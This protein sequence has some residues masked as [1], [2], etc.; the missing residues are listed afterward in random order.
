MRDVLHSSF[1][2]L[3]RIYCLLFLLIGFGVSP[4]LVSQEC[5]DPYSC[6]SDSTVAQP[7]SSSQSHP[8][9][10]KEAILKNLLQQPAIKISL[11]NIDIQWGITQRS[12]SPFDPVINSEILHTYSRDL[13]NLSPFLNT[14][15]D[16]PLN[17]LPNV[18]VNGGVINNPN[19]QVICSCPSDSSCGTTDPDELICPPALHTHKQAHETTVHV[20]VRQKTREGTRLVL[21]VDI[22]QYKNPIVCPKRLNLGSVT[23]EI[24]QPLLR[25]FRY[26]LDRMNELAN[27][28]ELEA[29]R[30]DTLQLISQQVFNTVSLYWDTLAARRIV[31][32]Q[33]DSEERLTKIVENVKF[34]IQRGQLAP[35]DLLQPIAQLSSQIV[36]RVGSEQAYYEL[37]QQLKFIIGE[38]DELCPCST[39]EF[40]VTDDFPI[41]DLNPLAFPSLFC[42]LFPTVY[43][44]R[45]DIMASVMRESKYT[46]LLKG[47]KNFELPQLDVVGRARFT[48]FTDCSRSEQLFSSLRFDQPQQDYS[49]GVVFSTPFFRDD[50]KGLIR[51]RQAE[52]SQAQANTQ[53]LKQQALADISAALRD[54]LNLQEEIRKAKEAAE[55]YQQLLINER[56][57]LIAGYSTIFILL[58]FEASLTNAIIA[59]IRLQSELAKN[60]SRIRFLTGTLVQFLPGK[61]CCRS[62]VIG[63]AVTLPFNAQAAKNWEERKDCDEK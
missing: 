1:I 33:K 6:P 9:S 43:D 54:Q 21:S 20:D 17:G 46:L 35:A 36:A 59:H 60:I 25:D 22:D 26:G 63:D 37:Q 11:Y 4:Q 23:M 14:A 27:L 12:A 38:W 16:V 56:K 48:D 7:H 15:Q 2:H 39:K 24:N 31:Q 58:S 42:S 41:T 34:L 29:V 32:A 45:F 52:W 3:E 50:A 8:L 18:N 5:E 13:L 10:L 40:D 49:V 62:F 57:K 53:L 28:Q 55:E 61:G 47:A 44:W 30:Y 19:Q 51:Q